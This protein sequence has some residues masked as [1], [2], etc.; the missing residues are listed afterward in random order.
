MNN[1][2]AFP[3]DKTI[4]NEGHQPIIEPTA[5]MNLR[6]YFAAHYV[7]NRSVPGWMNGV[8]ED[9]ERQSIAEEAYKM[10]DAMMKARRPLL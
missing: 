7:S 9:M 8:Q 6:D 4:Y 5:G 2:K 3:F 10:A 1:T